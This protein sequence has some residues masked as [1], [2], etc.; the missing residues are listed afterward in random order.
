M[1]AHLERNI[2]V[3]ELPAAAEI[4]KRKESQLRQAQAAGRVAPTLRPPELLR[5]ITL[6]SQMWCSA[7]PAKTT[8]QQ[9]ARCTAI[10]KAIE[11]L[12][13]VDQR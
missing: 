4:R 3:M 7:H 12:V 11:R 1:W 8:A 9:S 2:D 5:L 13:V 10:R 6:L